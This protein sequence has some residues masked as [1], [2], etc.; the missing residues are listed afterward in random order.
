MIL[1]FYVIFR[2]ELGF[3]FHLKKVD[4]FE[5]I[6]NSKGY[7]D[8]FVLGDSIYSVS[9]FGKEKESELTQKVLEAYL[10]EIKG[11]L[12]NNGFLDNLRISPFQYIYS[13]FSEN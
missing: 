4:C 3:V 1:I 5:G 7:F 11:V 13:L 8:S 9:V 2:K 6:E 12:L 10:P